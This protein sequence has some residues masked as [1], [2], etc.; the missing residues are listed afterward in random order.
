MIIGITVSLALNVLLAVLFFLMGIAI[1]L[2]GLIVAS[3]F[4][5]EDCVSRAKTFQMAIALVIYAFA[6]IVL[7]LNLV[8]MAVRVI[9]LIP[10]PFTI[11]TH[12]FIAYC[13]F[14]VGVL[15]FPAAIK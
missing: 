14:A 10:P 3:F 2:G 11:M 15:I 13:S 9:S 12:P 4:L 1:F 5:Q 8:D 7:M 6:A